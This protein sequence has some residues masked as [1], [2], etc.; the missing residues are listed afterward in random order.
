MGKSKRRWVFK[1]EEHNIGTITVEADNYDEAFDLAQCGDG[2]IDI[3][4]SDWAIE[5]EVR[6]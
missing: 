5:G 1:Y 3:N 4:K 2:D 6:M